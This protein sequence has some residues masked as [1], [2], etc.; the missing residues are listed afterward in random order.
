MYTATPA[1]TFGGMAGVLSPDPMAVGISMGTG[2]L[3]GG[4]L[5]FASENVRP[6]PLESIR[7]TDNPV[8]ESIPLYTDGDL[9]EGMK[10]V[11]N[12]D[13][14]VMIAKED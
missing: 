11:K 9:P 2:G 10:L 14:S 4:L 13:G 6:R 3:M 12:P 1:L 8:R 5:F 7:W